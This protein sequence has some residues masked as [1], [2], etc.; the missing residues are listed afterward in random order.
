VYP[1]IFG[2]PRAH[3]AFDASGDFLDRHQQARLQDLLLAYIAFAAKLSTPRDDAR[4]A[5]P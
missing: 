5:K 3:Q 2:L 4:A 1:E